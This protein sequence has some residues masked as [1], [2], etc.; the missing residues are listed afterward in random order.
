MHNACTLQP[1]R[2]TR[3]LQRGSRSPRET[4]APMQIATALDRPDLWERA[5]ELDADVWPKYNRHGDVLNR[6]WGRLDKEFAGHQFVLYDDERDELLAEGHTIP[7]RWDGSADG[8]P[9]GID[10]L[11]IDAFALREQGGEANTLAALAAEIPPAHQSRGLSRA[12][13][14]GMLEI[15]RRDGLGDLVAPARPSWKERYPLTPIERYV[16]WTTAEG[17]PFDPWMRVHVRMG[18]DVLKAE[19]QSLLI[20]GSV[21]DWESWTGLAF[22]E[23]TDYVF[24]HG[25]A[26]VRIDREAGSGV[27]RKSTR[28]NSSH[29]GI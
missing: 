12:V 27:D 19:P 28:L 25:L 11:I 2:S 8:L 26:P 4:I 10:G 24:P 13:L 15:A 22:P 3:S 17:L 21:E 9:A 6:Y 29:L 1:R 5:R 20:S 23:S 14:D 16:T 7:F 18:A